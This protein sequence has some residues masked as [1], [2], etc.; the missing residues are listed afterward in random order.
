[1]WAGAAALAQAHY[2]ARLVI[3]GLE[4]D[5]ADAAVQYN[6][7]LELL[8]REKGAAQARCPHLFCVRPIIDEPSHCALCGA[9]EVLA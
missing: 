7:K 2:E 4:R 3:A 9:R 8:E 6:R 5:R 1:M